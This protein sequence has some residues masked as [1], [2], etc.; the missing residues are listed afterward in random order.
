MA[1]SKNVDL[2]DPSEQE[3]QE[4]LPPETTSQDD[5]LDDTIADPEG[6]EAREPQNRGTLYPTYLYRDYRVND[7]D[8]L[9]PNPAAIENIMAH[10]DEK[11]DTEVGEKQ[12]KAFAKDVKTVV[13]GRKPTLGVDAPTTGIQMLRERTTT[14]GEFVSCVYDYI[15]SAETVGTEKA[16]PDWLIER[17]AKMIDLGYKARVLRNASKELFADFG[18]PGS[19]ALD[20]KRVQQAVENRL[21]RLAAWHTNQHKDSTAGAAKKQ[22]KASSEFVQSI[23][24]NA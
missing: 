6:A 18:L 14:W 19:F 21:T 15:N 4:L 24:D 2:F 5:I 20:R 17:E 13:E 3:T 7:N 10:F 11:Q 22:Q 8:D 9:E 1:K 23:A 12:A 16:M